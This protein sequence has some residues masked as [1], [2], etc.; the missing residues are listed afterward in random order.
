M[1]EAVELTNAGESTVYMLM[2]MTDYT[3]AKDLAAADGFVLV[4]DG[5]DP[6]LE[7]HVI[8]AGED[9]EE[10]DEDLEDEED[11]QPDEDDEEIAEDPEE[12]D[13]P[14]D[15]PAENEDEP[16]PEPDPQP[17]KSSGKRKAWHEKIV[18]WYMQ[19][20]Q[21]EWIAQELGLNKNTVIYHLHKEGL[22]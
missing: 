4:E 16:E 11:E 12:E 14:E 18:N 20:R 13:E 22:K 15:E 10:D 9:P 8:H 2:P 3:F 6:D 19:G 21:P 5:P 7:T 17:E 1:A